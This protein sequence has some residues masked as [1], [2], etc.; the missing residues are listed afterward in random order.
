MNCQRKRVFRALLLALVAGTALCQE[1]VLTL[2]LEDAV[3]SALENNVAIKQSEISLDAKKRAARYSWNPVSPEI[4]LDGTYSIAL[5]NTNDEDATLTAGATISSTLTPSLYTSIKGA[6]IERDLQEM[7]FDNDIRA[8]ELEV[9]KNYYS[10]LY[11]QQQVELQEKSLETTKKQ[12]ESNLAKY[13]R[14]TLSRLDVL[15]AQVS[16]QNDEL[17]LKSLKSELDN[18]MA[19]FKQTI[20]IPQSQKIE[21]SGSFDDVLALKS[22]SV[23]TQDV[24]SF[25]VASLESQ[26]DSAKNSLLASRF[27]AWGPSLTAS[28]S[29]DYWSYDSGATWDDGG[30]FKV[31][32]VIPLDGYLPWSEGAQGIATQKDTLADLELQLEDAKTSLEVSLSTLQNQIN[33]YLENLSLR[34]NSIELAQTTYD[35]TQDAYNHGTKDLLSL[36]SA[37]DEL[38]SSRVNL[39]YEAYNLVCALLDLENTI[40]LPFGTLLRGGAE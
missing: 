22:I 24:R 21:L 5:P 10:L 19:S 1:E 34:Q 2:T 29:Y 39:I 8:V 25:D 30:T 3:Q 26:I 11:Q 4:S 28:Y 40:G 36:Q 23:D 20:G 15:S 27:S 38:L 33:Q 35:M 17:D 9:R 31:S 6:D 7:I 37:F 32:V 18:A 16:Y 14:G 13:N 12:Y